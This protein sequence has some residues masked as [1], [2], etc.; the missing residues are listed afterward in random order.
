MRTIIMNQVQNGNSNKY[1]EP[2]CYPLHPIPQFYDSRNGNGLGFDQSAYE[3]PLT[4]PINSSYENNNFQ[5]QQLL[6]KLEL[7]GRVP[8]REKFRRMICQTY[9]CCGGCPYNER[10][11]FLHDD[12]VE[13]KGFKTRPNRQGKV[14]N[15]CK[16]SFYWPDMPVSL[17]LCF[18]CHNYKYF[19]K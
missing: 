7:S 2:Q 13:L 15:G 8:S 14:I 6:Q 1:Y 3:T 17:Y 16:D 5:G 11:V 4:V 18:T 9:V 12:R 10:C 19:L